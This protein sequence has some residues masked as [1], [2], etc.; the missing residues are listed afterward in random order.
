MRLHQRSAGE[1]V[2]KDWSTQTTWTSL[3]RREQQRA[4][5]L[6]DYHLSGWGKGSRVEVAR[7]RQVILWVQWSVLELGGS[8]LTYSQGGEGQTRGVAL[9]LA[10][11]KYLGMPVM[12]R[13]TVA[14]DLKECRPAACLYLKKLKKLGKTPKIRRGGETFVEPIEVALRRVR[15]ARGNSQRSSIPSLLPPEPSCDSKGMEPDRVR[16]EQALVQRLVN[17]PDDPDF[18]L[19]SAELAKIDRG[20]PIDPSV[21][22]GDPEESGR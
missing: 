12:T 16:A 22:A 4:W 3:T 9:C 18:D 13:K 15:G 5:K 17:L 19:I 2:P 1:R 14:R 10:V 7:R 20:H 8:V 21:S 6:G 11:L